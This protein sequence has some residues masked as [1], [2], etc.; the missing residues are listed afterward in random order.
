MKAL[1]WTANA[2]DALL[3]AR[4][5]SQHGILADTRWVHCL[6][7][8]V[9]TLQTAQMF[10]LIVIDASAATRDDAS[11]TILQRSAPYSCVVL[12]G[13]TAHRERFRAYLLPLQALELLKEE[14]WRL[15][16][17]LRESADQR[18]AISKLARS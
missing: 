12:Y 1:H 18:S 17:V 13:H 7:E 11:L 2:S 15:P 5:L 6:D 4:I 8:F 16:L 9:A 10:D 3:V 14:L